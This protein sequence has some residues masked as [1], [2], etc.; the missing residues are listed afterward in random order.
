MKTITPTTPI[1]PFPTTPSVSLFLPYRTPYVGVAIVA[2]RPTIAIAGGNWI[3]ARIYFPHCI[4]VNDTI[5]LRFR[6]IATNQMILLQKKTITDQ[7]L[8]Q[9]MEFANGAFNAELDL[10]STPIPPSTYDVSFIEA[11]S[12]GATRSVSFSQRYVVT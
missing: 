5:Q 9:A 2:Q 4:R 6:N 11:D 7:I 10:T 12:T 8:F 3:S 1:T